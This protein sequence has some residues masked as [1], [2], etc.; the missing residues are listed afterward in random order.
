M[1]NLDQNCLTE[2]NP[3]PFPDNSFQTLDIPVDAFV[4]RHLGVNNQEK[5]QMLQ[6]LGV[7]SLEQ[8]IDLT[9]PSDIRLEKPLNL[10]SAKSE[11]E[12]LKQLKEIADQNQ[13]FRSYIGMGYHD[14]ITPA[15]I[16]RNIL[17]NPGW[18]TAY[19]PY[20]A[21][22]AQG[23]LEALLNF[24]T[25]IM[26]LTGLE[27]ANASLLDE[28]T[29]AAEA[30]TM[31]YAVSKTK[32]KSFFISQKCHPQTIAVIQTRANPLNIE[33]IV[34][35]HQ[36]FNFDIAIFGALLPYPATDGNIYNYQEFIAKAHQNKALVTISADILS[37]AL[38]KSPAEL[39][40]DIAVGNTQRFGVPLGY[41]GPHAAYFATKEE[42][43]RQIPGRIVGIS[44]D[45]QGNKA[46]RLALQTREQHIRREK[47]TSNICTAQV[48]LAVIASMY[49]VYHG[50]EGIKNIAQKVH[51]L[52]AILAEGLRKL[53]YKI[54]NENFFDT[55]TI[56]LEKGNTQ[57]ILNLAHT[58]KINLRYVD[59]DHLGISLDET[60]TEK[61][62]RELWEIFA[63]S[64][65]LPFNFEDI[66]NQNNFNLPSDLIRHSKYL[67]DPI[68]NRH[69]SETE[70]LRYLHQL[71]QKDLSLT[72]L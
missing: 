63:Q 39:G 37:L 9:I 67:T 7:S 33:I 50:A 71:E 48:L 2:I 22:I 66:K 23:R 20:Q 58:Q 54:I 31:S 62:V 57:S 47:A 3:K 27:I 52:T 16:Q 40:A 43:K 6:Y 35:D 56:K 17:E 8:L 68:F 34:G 24:Q 69:H 38:L 55:L 45:S 21:E 42:Y 46:F 59:N 70:L 61:D 65:E 64:K 4:H 26:E 51:H 11:Y 19:T 41:G 30:M 44:K 49:A 13:I 25:M 14:C 32:A 29:A 5:E 60:V 10:P 15:V 12:A 53:N 36:D 1:W 28:A 72:P 18:Y